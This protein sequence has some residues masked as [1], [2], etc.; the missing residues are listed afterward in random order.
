MLSTEELMRPRYKVIA[1]YP[2]TIFKPDEIISIHG[3]HGDIIFCDSTGPRYS[4]Y[5]HLFK[6][7]AWHEYRTLDELYSLKYAKVIIYTGYWIVGDIVPVTKCNVI[8][9]NNVEYILK[10]SQPVKINTIEP[11]SEQQY[12][13]T[14]RL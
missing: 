13:A 5:P 14:K 11:A 6:K 8:D 4:D 7:L 9:K 2:K 3:M 12:L 1:S 10:Y